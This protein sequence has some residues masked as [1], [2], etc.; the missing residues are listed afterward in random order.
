MF[1]IKK[2]LATFLTALLCAISSLSHAQTPDARTSRVQVTV[3]DPSGGAIPG[4]EVMLTGLENATRTGV[5]LQAKTNDKGVVLFEGATPGRYSISASFPG[6]D[7]GLLR[8]IRTRAGGE[9]RH[10][11]VLP[12][13]N[14][15]DSVTVGRDT[16]EAAA[17]RRTSE[18]G[19]KLSD[20]QINAL[21]DDPNELQRQL[22]ELAGLDAVIRVDSFEGQQL[23]PKSQIKSIHV[24]RDQFAAEAANPGSTFVDIVTQPGIGAIRG[25]ANVSYRN[26]ALTGK[27]QFS[28]RSTPEQ[29]RNFGGNVGGTIIAGRTSFNAQI[30]GQN[31]YTSPIL[32]VTLPTGVRAETLSIRQ[33]AKAINAN[34]VV[35][36]ALTRDQVVKVG[37]Q[38][39]RQKRENMGIGGYNLPERGFSQEERNVSIRVQEAGPIGRRAFLNTRLSTRFTNLDMH[40]AS[41]Q[42]TIVVQDAFSAGGAQNEQFADILQGSL[43]SDIDYI[44][45]IHSWRAGVQI[46]FNK[47][48]ARSRFNWLGTYTFA[49]NEDYVAGRPILYTRSLG[50][51]ENRYHNIQG[52]VYVQDD[53]RV[54]KGLTFSPGLRYTMQTRLDDR[55]GFAPRFGFTWSPFNNG[56]TTFRG[57]AGIFHGFL[58]LVMIEQTIRLDGERQQE[59]YVRN[60]SYPDVGPV[61]ELN[62]PT[63]KYVIG[64]FNL[65]RNARYSAGIDQIL[66]PRIRVNAL[67]NYIHQQ[68]QPRGS[69]V[70][71]LVNGVRADPRYANVIEAVTDAEIR[72]HEFSVN[73]IVALAAPGPGLSANF[74]NWRR[75][76]MNI[77]YSTV[78][79]QNN[80]DGAWAVSPSGNVEDDWGPGPGDQPYRIQVLLTSN[81]I[82]NVTANVTYSANS[83]GPYTLLTGFDDNGD[84]FLNDRPAGV[85]LRSLRG[86]DQQTLS[87]RVQYALQMSAAGTGPGAGPARYRMNVFVNIQNLTNHQNL[88]GYSGVM[89]SQNFMKPTLVNNPRRVDMGIGINF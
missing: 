63:N 41:N 43:A 23:P 81:Q 12:L 11:V 24:T 74:F 1:V 3:V 30:N 36:H 54:R 6:F 85:G 48:V 59:I 83:G 20:D 78:R 25:Q 47:F 4:A 86:A 8:D 55:S 62:I 71:P 56:A 9:S 70:N 88:G 5:P 10:V 45:G 49:N 89:T 39:S 14:L 19:L 34:L 76:N 65:Q 26:G 82:R 32:N 52:A 13:K 46:D 18:F 7:L 60:P 66:S 77:G 33:P 75:M 80:S 73:A 31:D 53:I 44:R 17:D 2:R 50:F 61:D 84:G 72:R 67:Y 28:D 87:A 38:F 51:P 64:D 29:T 58:P 27:S 21:S 57:S 40:S 35:D 68:Q 16:Q 42:P 15:Q 37:L 69:N 79:A 22:A